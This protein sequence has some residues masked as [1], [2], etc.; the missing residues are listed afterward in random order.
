MKINQLYLT[1]DGITETKITDVKVTLKDPSDVLPF[2]NIFKTT[3]TEFTNWYNT[4]LSEAE[5]F[6]TNNIHSFENNLPEYIRESSD[7]QDMKD[8][9]NL[10]GEQY[11]LIRNHIDSL[12]TLHKRGYKQTD[13]PPD[14]TL[15]M[16]LSNI[17]G[18]A[19]ASGDLTFNIQSQYAGV[20]LDFGDSVID[21][22][23][24]FAVVLVTPTSNNQMLFKGCVLTSLS[25]SADMAEEA[26]RFKVSGTFKSGCVPTLNDTDIDPTGTTHFNSNYFITDYGDSNTTG[27]S[28]VIA[29]L[30]DPVL[31]SFSLSIENDAVFTGYDANGNYQQIHRAIPEV[32]VLFDAVVKYDSETEVLAR[33]FEIQSTSTVANTLTAQNTTPALDISVPKAILTDVSFSEDDAMFVSVSTKAVASATGSDDLVSVNVQV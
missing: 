22:T 27:A 21:N 17:T 11:D 28:T 29:G 24:T 16:L 5:T 8:F 20:D 6:D 9:L 26:G 25:I 32:S 7:Y 15:P 30:S 13:S 33:N 2:D 19:D 10:Q 1:P 31:K 14:N 4:A 3:S 12:G 18:V 23:K